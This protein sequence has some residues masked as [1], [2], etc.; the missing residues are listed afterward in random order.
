MWVIKSESSLRTIEALAVIHLSA[1]SLKEILNCKYTLSELNWCIDCLFYLSH[2][3]F[4]I[5]L[6]SHFE[7][8][9]LLFSPFY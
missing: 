3:H 8:L 7:T 4:G 2:N 5:K 1:A 6:S 9:L